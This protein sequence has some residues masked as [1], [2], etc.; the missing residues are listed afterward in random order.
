MTKRSLNALV[1]ERLE[2]A[3]HH[4]ADEV[5][6]APGQHEANQAKRPQLSAAGFHRDIDVGDCH[7]DANRLPVVLGDQRALR[8]KERLE[9]AD[10]FAE[11][12]AADWHGAP[13]FA[14]SL[15]VDLDE[16][17][18]LIIELRKVS[19]PHGDTIVS[20]AHPAKPFNIRWIDLRNGHPA[21]DEV[22]GLGQ[23]SRLDQSLVVRWVPRREQRRW[24]VKVIHQ[25]TDL[26]VDSEAGRTPHFHQFLLTEPL[27]G[28]SKQLPRDGRVI[29]AFEEP[30]KADAVIVHLEM[31]I[32]TDGGDAT[33]RLAVG[34]AGNKKLGV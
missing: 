24:R 26:L 9:F 27:P 8:Q 20:R 25:Q 1:A 22:F 18:D 17:I 10:K 11:L 32:E 14:P 33:N 19:R 30:E 12:S 31:A 15:G 4:A 23:T 6:P 7:G 28:S 3:A 29:D 21:R 13:V 5:D 34:I 2:N 16:N